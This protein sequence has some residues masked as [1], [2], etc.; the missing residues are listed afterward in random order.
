V[1]SPSG[2]VWGRA[3]AASDFLYIIYKKSLKKQV[4]ISIRTV[5]LEFGNVGTNLGHQ[6]KNGTSGRPGRT[7]I[8]SRTRHWDCPRKSGTDGH[9]RQNNCFLTII[10]VYL[11]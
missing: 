5:K 11:C 1:S 10:K 8:F 4:S 9:L 7:V 3:P 2:A 6:A